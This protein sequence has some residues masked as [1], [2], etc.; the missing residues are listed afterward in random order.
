MGAPPS[1]SDEDKELAIGIL[2]NNNGNLTKASG[3]TGIPISTLRGWWIAK[4]AEVLDENFPGKSLT[5]NQAL[6]FRNKCWTAICKAFKRLNHVIDKSTSPKELAVMI[7]LLVAKARDI[8][9]MPKSAT[10]K[11]AAVKA[12]GD[13]ISMLDRRLNEVR[14][15]AQ[16]LSKGPAKKEPEDP[17]VEIPTQPIGINSGSKDDDPKPQPEPEA[18]TAL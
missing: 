3:I 10:R 12:S 1:Y 6:A 15:T 17:D 7:T 4:Q 11:K 14:D 9:A 2:A 13:T 18:P 16:S 5:D 8:K